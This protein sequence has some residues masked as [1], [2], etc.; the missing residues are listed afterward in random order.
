MNLI[1][2]TIANIKSSDYATRYGH[3]DPNDGKIHVLYLAAFENG[4]GLYRAIIP[5]MELNKTDTHS[6]IVNQLEYQTPEIEKN[7]FD[8]KINDQILQWA[9]YV[10]FQKSTH[11]L[12]QD[13]ATIRDINKKDHLKFVM[14]IDDNYHAPH[15][16]QGDSALSPD[17]EQ[18]LRNMAA[19]DIITC[20]NANII[21][22]YAPLLKQFCEDKK[23][24]TNVSLV[25]FPNLMSNDCYQGV[26]QKARTR[27]KIRIGMSFNP[28]QF[29]DVYPFRKTLI[30]VNKKYKNRVE[31]IVFGWNGKIPKPYRN[32]LEGVTFIHVQAVPIGDYFQTLVNL[33]LDF[34]LMPLQ[35]NEFNRCKT[36]HKLLQYSQIGIPAVCSDVEPYNHIISEA[37]NNDG[38]SNDTLYL[39]HLKAKNA[40]EWLNHIDFYV[41]NTEKR[42]A[43]G[44]YCNLYVQGHYTWHTN[45]NV[46]KNLFKKQ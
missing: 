10:V 44:Y 20:A 25:H 9:D 34:C 35:D 13:I 16:G 28:T 24:A 11:N 41:N 31:L 8:V 36:H 38:T 6:A 45:I 30:E 23:I 37:I 40:E 19:C 39:P 22:F 14:D 26:I 32:A 27:D 29:T 2:Q 18:V 7:G 5:A 3:M 46:I 4:T 43:M 1:Q 42:Q 17:R 15:G 33:H 12:A 21:K